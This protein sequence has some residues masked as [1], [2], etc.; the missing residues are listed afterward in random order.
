M[1]ILH[2]RIHKIR[3]IALLVLTAL[4]FLGCKNDTGTVEKL[5]KVKEN[6]FNSFKKR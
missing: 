6:Y 5:N 4:V 1:K 3:T 2:N